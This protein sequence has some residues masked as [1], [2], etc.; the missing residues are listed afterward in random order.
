MR[1]DEFYDLGL[2]EEEL[3][4]LEQSLQILDKAVQQEEDLPLP[5][6]LRGEALLHLLDGVGQDPLEEELQPK[7]VKPAGKLIFGVF[8]QKYVAAAAMLAM[9]VMVG[10]AYNRLPRTAEI[11]ASDSGSSE[12]VG[13]AAENSAALTDALP[14]STNGESGYASVLYQINDHYNRADKPVYDQDAVMQEEPPA[15]KNQSKRNPQTSADQDQALPEE[16]EQ[17]SGNALRKEPEAS[18]EAV[19]QTAPE[20]T[21]Q[22]PAVPESTEEQPTADS[23]PPEQPENSLMTAQEDSSAAQGNASQD[24]QADSLPANDVLMAENEAEASESATTQFRTAAA[25]NRLSAETAEGLTYTLVPNQENRCEAVLEVSTGETAEPVEVA[26]ST[27]EPMAYSRVLYD[28]GSLIVVGN[29][30]EYPDEY[31]GMTRTVYEEVGVEGEKPEEDLRNSFVEMTRVTVYAVSEQ[32]PADL[33]VSHSY[34][35][36]GWCR[37]A[38]VTE[39]GILYTVTNKSIYGVNG[40]TEYLTEVIPVVGSSG[41]LHYM[42]SSRIYVDDC[43]TELD[44]YV[45][46]TGLS[47]RDPQAELDAVAYLGDRMPVARI[48]GDGVYLGRSITGAEKQVSR[49]IRFDGQDLTSVTESQDISG[50]LIPGSFLSLPDTGCAVLTGEPT[51]YTGGGISASTVLVLDRSLGMAAA[52]EVPVSPEE[53]RS[54]EVGERIMLIHTADRIYQVDFSQSSSPEVSVRV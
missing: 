27:E 11:S 14:D 6:S 2:N 46:I 39:S 12:A 18:N 24:P 49:M 32:D 35:Q 45:V 16:T 50:L 4:D 51:E 7:S 25:A 31:L 41:E 48:A 5:E 33:S 47:L 52:A 43:S 30:L 15:E 8:P 42:D 26:I 53:I 54:V 13:Q 38:A 17:D 28:D 22:D 19:M 40:V 37:D 21:A 10:V 23:L 34:Y 44:S 1:I 9:A 36:A 3:A 29:L 20:N